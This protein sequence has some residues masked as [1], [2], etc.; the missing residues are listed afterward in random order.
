MTNQIPHDMPGGDRSEFCPVCG[1]HFA[2]AECTADTCNAL[3]E[4]S[5]YVD[6]EDDEP[7]H[8]Q[9]GEAGY[10]AGTA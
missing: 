7:G 10:W 6:L 5:H 4:T 1:Q 3:N 9:F 8:N 2:C